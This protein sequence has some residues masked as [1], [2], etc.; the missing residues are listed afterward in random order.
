VANAAI[1]IRDY[2]EEDLDAL[3]EVFRNSVLRVARLDYSE[4][5]VRAWAPTDIDR[6][7]V[8]IR[9]LAKPTWVAEIDGVFV[10]FADLERDGH[11]DRMFV[12]AE[13]QRRGIAS[14]LLRRVEAAAKDSNLARLYSEVSITA[15]PFFERRGLRMIAVQMVSVRGQEFT[16]YRMEKF[17]TPG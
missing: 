13:Y 3:I 9:N 14:A 8:A 11:L 10:G 7:A 1:H 15:R 6:S 2:R 5:Q 16:N 12:H 4:E 17:L